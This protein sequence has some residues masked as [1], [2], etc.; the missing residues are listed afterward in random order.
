MPMVCIKMDSV[1]VV[2]SNWS[3]EGWVVGVNV[4]WGTNTMYLL[5]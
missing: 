3:E 2:P 5:F 1:S 4:Q